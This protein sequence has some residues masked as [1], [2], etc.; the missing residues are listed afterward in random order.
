MEVTRLFDILDRYLQEY[1]EQKVALAGKVNTEWREYSPKEYYDLVNCISC[2]L[3]EDGIKPGDKV[4]LISGNKPEWNMV[5]MAVM[6]LGC[7]IVP[8]YP[9]ISESDYEYILNH[10]EAKIAIVEGAKIAEKIKSVSA[11]LQHLQKMYTFNKVEGY[12]EFAE[13][14]ENGKNHLNLDK[15]KELK[16]AVKPEDCSTIIYTSGTTGT[17]KGVMLSHKNIVHQIMGII[18][19]P[20][21]WSK[22]A[23]SFLPLC[24]AYERLL[25]F[26]YQYLGMSVYYAQNLGTI[27]ENLREVHP[28][29][30]TAVPRVLEKMFDKVYNNGKKLSGMK[31]K[32]F[33][34]AID[35]AQQYKIQDFE[36]S[37]WYNFKLKI[38]DKLVYKQIRAGIGAEN[39]DIIVSGAASIQPRIASFFSAIKMPVFEGYGLTETS[40]VISVSC[41]KK[42]G[43]EVGTVGFPLPGIEVKIDPNTNEVM[44]RGN[45][46]MM[47]YYKNPEL[48][49]EV[50]DP[51]G[52]F[53]TGDC[54]YLTEHNQLVLTGRLKNIFKTSFG[55]YV[56]PQAIENKFEE[57]PFIENMV[58]FGENQKFPAALIY[59]D[60]S[61]LKL[62]CSRHDVEYT[63]PVDII[64][65]PTIIARFNRELDKYNA[66]FGDTEKVKKIK[67]ISDEWSQA[68]GILTPTL[69]VKRGVVAERY[70]KEIEELFA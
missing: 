34:W 51:D 53:H 48:T 41:R 3:L 2:G 56:N 13:L 27:A 49:K 4:A 25:V 36:R 19:T 37:A 8:V 1:P 62:W 70:K 45:N 39:F 57:S 40:P 47:G 7:I 9:T 14:V 6:Q 69:K 68:T 5:D 12:P 32:I 46:V 66:F 65:N 22:R 23:F 55:K 52:W 50:I 54:G 29:M 24:H 38:A 16:S 63:D 26:M 42:Y 64:K 60:F 21:P 30:M 35:L 44:C 18:M 17:P 43:R 11:N 59:P 20:S 28:T 15:L 31:K 61:F 58:V 10:S 67:L 33:Y